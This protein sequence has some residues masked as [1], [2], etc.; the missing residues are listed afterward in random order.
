MAGGVGGWG[1]FVCVGGGGGMVVQAPSAVG[2][3][4]SVRVSCDKTLAFSFSSKDAARLVSHL[5]VEGGG[6]WG[7]GGW[8]GGWGVGGGEGGKLLTHMP[9]NYPFH[10]SRTFKGV[11]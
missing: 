7:G 3:T 10:H 11:S 2:V 5:C 6:G 9:G 4:G 1:V 8:V